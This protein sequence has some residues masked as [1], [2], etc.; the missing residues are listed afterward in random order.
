MI[1]SQ[2]F[3]ASLKK[4]AADRVSTDAKFAADIGVRPTAQ[5]RSHDVSNVKPFM[6]LGDRRSWR[7]AFGSVALAVLR[8]R[9]QCKVLDRVVQWVAVDVMNDLPTRERATK[10]TLHENAVFQPQASIDIDVTVTKLLVDVPPF[11]VGRICSSLAEP[12]LRRVLC[13]TH[14]DIVRLPVATLKGA[15]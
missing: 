13:L 8:L 11:V 4:A 3:D 7:G 10:M 1:A 14:V 12:V 5:V 15:L 9:H 6:R 2:P